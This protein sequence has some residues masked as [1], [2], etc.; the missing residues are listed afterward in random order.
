MQ[1]AAGGNMWTKWCLIFALWLMA[2]APAFSA[3]ETIRVYF[4]TDR[5]PAVIK[6]VSTFGKERGTLSVGYCDVHVPENATELYQR[7][8]KI[9]N[10]KVSREGKIFGK[11][12]VNRLRKNAG[13]VHHAVG[14]TW[15]TTGREELKIAGPDPDEFAKKVIA[16]GKPI[17][18][19]VHGFNAKF[20]DVLRNAARLSQACR[21]NGRDINV[22]L[23]S[24]PSMASNYDYTEDMCNAE[25]ATE[26]YIRVVHAFR[27]AKPK[28]LSLLAH[29]MGNELLCRSLAYQPLGVYPE[30]YKPGKLE[31]VIMCSPDVDR[32]FAERIR[33][34]MQKNTDKMTLFVSNADWPLCLS[35][36]ING[37]ARLGRPTNPP[38]FLQA[39]APFVPI[40]WLQLYP[41]FSNKMSQL[42]SMA[43]VPA[44]MAKAAPGVS[45]MK[46]A[47]GF[48][49]SVP[50]MDGMMK[51]FGTAGSAIGRT[52]TVI[53]DAGSAIG[54]A[55]TRVLP[56]PKFGNTR[57]GK[58]KREGRMTMAPRH[59]PKLEII[60]FTSLD[61]ATR[62]GHNV[63]WE[64]V[65]ALLIGKKV[66]DLL[67]PPYRLTYALEIP[68]STGSLPYWVRRV[69]P[70]PPLIE[71]DAP[72]TPTLKA[73]GSYQIATDG[74]CRCKVS[75]GRFTMHEVDDGHWAL[76]SKN[77]T[78]GQWRMGIRCTRNGIPDWSDAIVT[79]E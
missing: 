35:R 47:A 22:V 52:G 67:M 40:S 11:F 65:S 43:V 29:S 79:V 66:D 15:K 55:S 4:A 13:K 7:V 70:F 54:S 56:I 37:H 72:L 5:Q 76:R 12:D 20:E 49:M 24:W 41:E 23:F 48:A 1:G 17:C 44:D 68:D 8:D 34:R 18:I 53:G 39:I 64:L 46:H 62:M 61:S 60:D 25:W 78:A 31:Q 28:S 50:G 21:R 33:E 27:A 6:K 42:K 75:D 74:R 59:D 2:A 63:Q 57:V 73:G 10:E 77:A 32:L 16:E 14:T 71:L 51:A 9:L 45:E 38:G 36:L 58:E 19:Y 3:P 69:T 26:D 30:D